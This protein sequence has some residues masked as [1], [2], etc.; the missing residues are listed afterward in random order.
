MTSHIVVPLDD[1]PR[2]KHALEH[3][4]V[5][6]PGTEITVLHVIDPF[7]SG[8]PAARILPGQWEDWY[9][10]E[11][12]EVEAL[13]EE[14]RAMAEEYDRE[15]ETVAETGP[16]AETIIDCADRTDAD[17]IVI[18]SHSRSMVSRMLLGSVAEA[19]VRRASVPVTVVR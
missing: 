14:A 10:R 8:D 1:S 5:E 11:Q 18:G 3:A 7:G 13:F 16:T 19:V 4:L 6:H 17:H 2:S 15:V 9:D 12:A